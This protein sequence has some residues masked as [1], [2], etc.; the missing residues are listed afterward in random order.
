MIAV[1]GSV[2]QAVDERRVGI[3]KDLLDRAGKLIGRLSPVVVFHRDHEN[4]L[5]WGATV[6]VGLPLD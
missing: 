4:R 6:R 5:D 3:L 1:G 2:D